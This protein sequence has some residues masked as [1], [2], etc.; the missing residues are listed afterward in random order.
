MHLR[1]GH[2]I[3]L[4]T[5]FL[6]LLAP[7]FGQ[8]DS[9]GLK[10]AWLLKEMFQ[11]DD[12]EGFSALLVQDQALARRAYMAS[13]E[14]GLVSLLNDNAE[15]GQNGFVVASA[16]AMKLE[17]EYSETEP[18]LILEAFRAED[19]SA[20]ESFF[21][22]ADQHYPGY[23]E[24]LAAVKSWLRPQDSQGDSN[25]QSSPKAMPDPS[26]Y[27]QPIL[28]P[29][30]ISREYFRVLE[31]YLVKLQRIAL[32]KAFDDSNLV[33]QE[34]DTLSLVEAALLSDAESAGAPLLEKVRADLE[35]LAPEIRQVRL[36]VLAEVGLLDQFEVELPTLLER[37]LSPNRKLDLLYTA[38][39]VAFRQQQWNQAQSFLQQMTSLLAESNQETSRAYRFAAKTAT[40]QMR[41]A[42]G[43]PATPNEVLSQFKK[44]WSE[45]DG[46]RAIS[47][48][49]EDCSWHITRWNARFWI[50][51]L[52]ELSDQQNVGPILQITS[53]CE[54]WL[55]GTDAF[56]PKLDTL[57]DETILLHSEELRGYLTVSVVGLDLM[58]YI[59]ETWKPMLAQGDQFA[60]VSNSFPTS[61]KE[62]SDSADQIVSEI[63]G[64]GFPVFRL[65]DSFLLKE[66]KARSRYL[67]A[68]DPA[69]SPEERVS[70][71]MEASSIFDTIE[72][73]ESYIDYHLVLGKKFQEWGHP[74]KAVAAWSKAYQTAEERSF[75][76]QSIEAA[77]LL[78]KEYGR[79]KD[80]DNA[81]LYASRATRAIV[82]E[83]DG[84]PSAG[85][86]ELASINKGLTEVITQAALESDQPEEAFAALVQNE[87]VKNATVRLRGN[88]DAAEES[89][90]LGSKKRQ[91][92]VLSQTVKELQ[93]LP[94][95]TTRDELLQRTEELLAQSKSEFLLQSRQIRQKFSKLYTTALR[96][97]PLN[98]PDIQ[99]VLPKNTAVVQYFPTEETLY[100][101]VVTDSK[102]RLRS[103]NH[104]KAKLDSLVLT[105]LKNM[106][107]VA[108]ND[109]VLKGN[110]QLL[111]QALIE[112]IGEDLGEADTIVFIPTGKLNLLPF[113]SLQ[114]SAGKY[115]VESKILLELAKPTDFLKMALSKPKPIGQIVAFANATLDLPAAESEGEMIKGLFPNSK[116]FLRKEASKE[117]LIKFGSQ[118]DVLHLATH[119][120]WD[121]QDSLKNHLKLSNNERLD[122]EEIFNLGLD[123]TSLVTLSACS[124]ALG[125]EQDVEYV[126]S[127]AEAFWIAGSS[128]VVA[129][130][131][132]VDDNSTNLLM[133]EFYR[134]LKEGKPR[135]AALRDAQLKVLQDPTYGHP[136]HWSGFL[137][138][139][140]YR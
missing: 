77:T 114:D 1:Y 55:Q 71:L 3:L 42:Q 40:F 16:I 104:T 91:M 63:D 35:L 21:Q 56:S 115:L 124:T 50:D 28:E 54:S 12:L 59:V 90:Q 4:L 111:Y 105:Y 48:V 41:Q 93:N 64:P 72:V 123:N 49:E 43:E 17:S 118:A 128:S 34:L 78:A 94:D 51:Q 80:W 122:Q 96:F 140:D 22:Y 47:N 84:G 23:R 31:P 107:R 98:L 58:I 75:V 38:Y 36:R 83:F 24:S 127:L 110:S 46:Y 132:K 62:I 86:G 116:L 65:G 81:R 119:G 68:L 20:I 33:I 9:E 18:A 45:L 26:L 60:T 52:N 39:R 7:C 137:L 129:S 76:K 138:F 135:G 66:L 85:R 27:G 92:A 70:K 5:L 53:A 102:F 108:N 61:V 89:Q 109:E 131:W 10:R 73:P 30:S 117:N 136:Y 101:F 11:R 6:A 57:D 121:A 126:A 87:Q 74:D 99:K 88:R 100:I 97:D 14:H 69:N 130:L 37:E 95:S 120:T 79:A 113:A 112:P 2:V 25:S 8:T 139:G 133:S 13:L 19:P 67:L 44:C 29:S 32:A 125:E 82:E 106:L 134:E 15:E 103:V